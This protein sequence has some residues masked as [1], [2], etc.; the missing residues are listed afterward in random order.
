VNFY[1]ILMMPVWR[2]QV[3]GFIYLE[4]FYLI[5]KQFKPNYESLY[6]T[7]LIAPWGKY[8]RYFTTVTPLKWLIIY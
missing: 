1:F 3:M 2:V 5:L 6:I 4:Y 7:V 8:Q